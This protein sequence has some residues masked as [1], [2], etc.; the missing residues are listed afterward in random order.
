M[1]LLNFCFTVTSIIFAIGIMVAL[2]LRRYFLAPCLLVISF[3]FSKLA[4][5]PM[6]KTIFPEAQNYAIF[7]LGGVVAFIF[8]MIDQLYF[9]KRNYN[10]R[11]HRE[12][13]KGGE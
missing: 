12:N 1:N 4:D 8:F 11:D 10:W 13:K 5:W 6:L 3:V 9:G 7:M 2:G